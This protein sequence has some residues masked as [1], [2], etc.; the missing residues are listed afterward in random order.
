MANRKCCICLTMKKT[1]Q[2]PVLT[3]KQ[4]RYFKNQCRDCMKIPRGT[5]DHRRRLYLS[6]YVSARKRGLTH[7]I[8]NQDIPLPERCIYL[9]CKLN[10][11]KRGGRARWNDPSIDRI[12]YTRGYVVGNIQVISYRAN[13]MKQNATEDQLLAFARGVLRVH[14]GAESAKKRSSKK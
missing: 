11:T 10:Y 1:S 12:D 9:D 2:F 6:S 13:L 3:F 5:R 4:W 7:A 14:G 8:K